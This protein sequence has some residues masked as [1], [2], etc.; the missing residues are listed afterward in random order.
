MSA[1]SPGWRG[2]SGGEA[3]INIVTADRN[4]AI[5]AGFESNDPAIMKHREIPII[6][7]AAGLFSWIQGATA[8][9][10]TGGLV[11]YKEYAF[12]A[13]SQAAMT[14]YSS[15]QHFASVDNVVTTSGETLRILPGD[16][17]L[18]I[19]NPGDPTSTAADVTRTIL[20][21]ERRFPQYAPKLENVRRAW[22]SLPKAAP[23][24]VVQ[25][26][27]SIATAPQPTPGDES[28]NVLRTKY[29][30]TY[31]SW[32]VTGMEGDTVVLSHADGISR[33]PISDLPNNL[34]GFP[35]EVMA[36]AEQL[37][38]RG[39]AQTHATFAKGH[40]HPANSTPPQRDTR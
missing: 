18:Y 19:P 2:Q 13:D 37:R 31:R 32:K 17:P 39:A 10:A 14:D 15:F 27:P 11:I 22:A 34:Y 30:E 23:A 9:G 38:E 5:S 26:T 8:L 33:V 20:A 40:A 28:A 1:A 4:R 12:D 36:R 3:R 16:E 21:A 24:I 7:L 6:L 29:G 35:P 25:P